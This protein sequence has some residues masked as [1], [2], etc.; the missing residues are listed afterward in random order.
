MRKKPISP[1]YKCEERQLGCHS[2]CEKYLEYTGIVA[3]NREARHNL[4]EQKYVLISKRRERER[5]KIKGEK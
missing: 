3:Q 4:N 5:A 2:S 1:C